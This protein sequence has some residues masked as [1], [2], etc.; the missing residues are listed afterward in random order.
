MPLGYSGVWPIIFLD[1]V[2]PN[3]YADGTSVAQYPG[4]KELLGETYAFEM[5]AFLGLLDRLARTA[6]DE[7][8]AELLEPVVRRRWQERLLHRRL[9][10]VGPNFDARVKPGAVIDRLRLPSFRRVSG[11][12]GDPRF[13]FETPDRFAATAATDRITLLKRAIRLFLRRQEFLG[14][15]DYVDQLEPVAPR[16]SSESASSL[17]SGLHNPTVSA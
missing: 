4:E 15:E 17:E 7:L 5:P 13:F 2:I 8:A 16:S 14:F 3:A 12:Q 11:Q 9:R 1:V 10:L 6:V